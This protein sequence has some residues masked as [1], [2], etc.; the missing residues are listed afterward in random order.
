MLL[1]FGLLVF[2]QFQ[3]GGKP[4]QPP[5][6]WPQGTSIAFD[7]RPT[8]VMMAHPYCACMR[9]T[10]DELAVIMERSHGTLSAKVLFLRLADKGPE[11][12]H[13]ATW[14]QAEKIP[15]VT[16]QEDVGGVEGKRFNVSISGEAALYDARGQLLFHGGITPSRGH[17]GDNL[18]RQRVLSLLTTG[19]ADR[20]DHPA[21]G[22]GLDAEEAKTQ[23]EAV[24]LPTTLQH[25]VLAPA[26]KAVC[27]SCHVMKS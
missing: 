17:E 13:T 24:A 25:P 1:G 2:H 19:K 27:G 18:G 10:L 6:Q 12:S 20:A 23:G 8:L 11:W 4:G 22:C 14:A 26:G 3:S 16:V 15:G 9:S 5:S 21:W 7:G